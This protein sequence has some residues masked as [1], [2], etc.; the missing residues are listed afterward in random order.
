MGNRHIKFHKNTWYH[1][2]NRGCNK[3]WIF[4]DQNDFERFYNNIARY[5]ERFPEILIP[6]WCLIP[7]HFHFLLSSNSSS[8]LNS[9]ETSDISHF[10]QKL[11]QAY[12]MY[13]NAKYG[14]TIK[15]G[16]KGPIF[17][18][19][20]QAI[21][22]YDEEYF[23][24]LIYYIENNSVRHGLV[25]DSRNWGW[26]SDTASSNSSSNLNQTWNTDDFDPYFE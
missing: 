5:K 14:D 3:Q 8:N 21:E 26:R 4:F 22:V 24:N 20:F 13:F 9:E 1:I 23:Q 25:D 19:R 17:E 12:A 6:V 18:G 16:K 15:N 2:Y 10:M 11:Q 7:N